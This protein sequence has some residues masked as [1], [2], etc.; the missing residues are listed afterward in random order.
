MDAIQLLDQQHDEADELFE[1]FDAAEDEGVKRRVFERLADL[2]AIHSAIEA[3][4]FYP[5]VRGA[6]TEELIIES[7]DEHE[8]MK[9]LLRELIRRDRIDSDFL[10]C[11][12]ELQGEVEYHVDEE[13]GELFPIARRLLD[14]ARLDELGRAMARTMAALSE[15]AAPRTSLGEAAPPIS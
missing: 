11:I 14:D 12:K 9:R 1:K 3:R 10:G 2:L 8:G 5:A 13:R 6:E 15:E 4:H 7:L